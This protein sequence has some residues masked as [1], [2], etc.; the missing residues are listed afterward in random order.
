MDQLSLTA[1]LFG[2]GALAF[3]AGN[4]A[5][6]ISSNAAF[7]SSVACGSTSTFQVLLGGF[8][9]QKFQGSGVVL[10]MQFRTGE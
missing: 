6:S 4:I 9:S 2:A 1:A 7:R 3:L 10:Y 8:M 5:L